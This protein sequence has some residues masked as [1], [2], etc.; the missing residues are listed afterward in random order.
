MEANPPSKF[1]G[2]LSS[3]FCE[4][5]LTNQPTINTDILWNQFD[6]RHSLPVNV[7]LFVP[8][9]QTCQKQKHGIVFNEEV[10]SD[11]KELLYNSFIALVYG[12]IYHC[13]RLLLASPLLVCFP[14]PL[15]RW[16]HDDL[17]FGRMMLYIQCSRSS[18]VRPHPICS[19]V[20]GWGGLPRK[21]L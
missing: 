6:C 15:F 3:S 5:L 8:M 17:P 1:N 18:P 4:I 13:K 12:A 2:Y 20:R 11:I 10:Q 7:V 9:S 21:K 19:G 16:S 14:S